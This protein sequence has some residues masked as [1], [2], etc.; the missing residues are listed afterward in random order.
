MVMAASWLKDIVECAVALQ[1]MADD[2][3]FKNRP[4][5]KRVRMGLWKF[6]DTENTKLE[7]LQT[8]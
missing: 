8:W 4:L 1:N 6:S 7:N 2:R 3:M 5:Q